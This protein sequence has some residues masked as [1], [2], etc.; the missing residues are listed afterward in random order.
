MFDWGVGEGWV[1]AGMF[2]WPGYVFH[3]FPMLFLV[4]LHLVDMLT[5]HF[6]PFKEGFKDALVLCYDFCNK[7]VLDV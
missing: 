5:W 3:R 4:Y 7:G 1:F 6:A 2:P